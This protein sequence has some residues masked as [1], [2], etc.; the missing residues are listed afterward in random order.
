[1]KLRSPVRWF[2]GKGQMLAKLLPIV[3]QGG[4][5][6]CEPYCGGASL[7]FA[8]DPAPVEVLN[9]LNGDLVNL[10]R[11]FQDREMFEDLRH[12]LMWTPYARAEFIRALEIRDSNETDPVLRAWAFFV[13]QNQGMSG[14]AKTAGNWSRVFYSSAGVADNVNKWFMRLSMLDAWRWR[15]MHAQIDNRDALEV[16][17]YWDSVDTVFYIDPPYHHDTRKTTD[18]YTHECEHEHHVQLVNVM[19]ECKG[20]VVLSGYAHD[21]YKPLEDAGWERI[22]FEIACHAA[23]RTRNSGLQGKGAALKKVKRVECVWRNPAA[24]K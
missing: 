4:K 22:D 21:V 11:C 2:G 15:L 10:F 16:I 12:R 19:L 6:Y 14:M 13:V 18:A 5:P 23:G 7:F 3:P 9:D 17:R 1:M 24:M 8:R 20:A